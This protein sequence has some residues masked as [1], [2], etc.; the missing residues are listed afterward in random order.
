MKPVFNEDTLSEGPALEQL[1]RLGYDYLPGDELDP[2][3]KE[4]CERA[5]RGEVVL[6]S[7]LKRKLAEI[8]PHLTEETVS[9]RRSGG[10]PTSRRR[11]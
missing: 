4:E 1:K 11:A 5:S 2:E 10:S 6:I 8:N 9:T 3:L 7:R